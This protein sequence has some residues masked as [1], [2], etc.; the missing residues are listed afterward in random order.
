VRA[1]SLDDFRLTPELEAWAVKES[2]ANPG[3]YVE[4]F[5]D[6]WRTAGG[7][8]KSGQPIK[9]WHAAFRNRLRMLKEQGKLRVPDWREQFLREEAQA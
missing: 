6:Y 2:I 4:E 3:Q 1:V 7:K 5:K 9:D 8:R